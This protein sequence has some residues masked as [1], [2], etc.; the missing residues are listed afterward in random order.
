MRPVLS[1]RLFGTAPVPRLIV[2]IV[3]CGEWQYH[4]GDAAK[5]KSPNY[6]R[7]LVGR[8]AV[9]I[10]PGVGYVWWTRGKLRSHKVP[11]ESGWSNNR[12]LA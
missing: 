9:V 4:P 5:R 11:D 6:L 7:R 8:S 3:V 12:L 10:G 2:L 1:V